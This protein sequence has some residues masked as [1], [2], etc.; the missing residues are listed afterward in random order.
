MI[1]LRY[2]AG[3]LFLVVFFQMFPFLNP[4]RIWQY[5]RGVAEIRSAYQ[6]GVQK[7][8]LPQPGVGEKCLVVGSRCGG[9]SQPSQ[10]WVIDDKG[11]R[12]WFWA[13]KEDGHTWEFKLSHT[14]TN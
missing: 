8:L 13:R 12:F 5:R 11:T 9:D 14:S 6:E 3:T 2:V 4:Y 7:G 1:A 10:V